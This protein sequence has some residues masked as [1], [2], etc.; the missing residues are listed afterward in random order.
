ML[1]R[2]LYEFI[3]AFCRDNVVCVSDDGRPVC[4]GTVVQCPTFA[5]RECFLSY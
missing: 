1:T 3:Y 4:K 2:F 5:D